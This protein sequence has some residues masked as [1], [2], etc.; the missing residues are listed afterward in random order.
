MSIAMGT[1]VAARTNT[2]MKMMGFICK[3]GENGKCGDG[4]FKQR[5]ICK[6]QDQHA[7]ST[8]GMSSR[9]LILI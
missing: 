1:A 9:A 4:G 2:E 8:T 5:A 3:D 7:I 6:F